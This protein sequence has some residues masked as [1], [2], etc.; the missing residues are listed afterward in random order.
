MNIAIPIHG[1]RV[2]PRFGYTRNV[3]IITVENG[4]S[5]SHKHV[6]ITPQNGITLPDLLISEG[7]SVMICGGIH[8]RFQ[9]FIQKQGIHLIWGIV[10]EWQDVLQAYLQGTLQSGSD[11]CVCRHQPQ[12]T[13]FRRRHQGRT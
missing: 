3:V 9:Q 4:Q 6:A 1:S 13:R 12:N 5:V 10:G 8:P 2:M 11:F 7:I